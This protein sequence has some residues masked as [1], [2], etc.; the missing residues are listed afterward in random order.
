MPEIFISYRREDSSGHAGRIFDCMCE[1]FSEASVFMD[2]TDIEPGVDF[3]AALDTALAS[4]RVVLVV[5]GT[6]WLTVM[7]SSGHRRLDDPEDHLRLEIARALA[8]DV[9]VIPIL[10]RGATMPREHDLPDDL[11]PLAHRQAHEL[12]DSRWAFD[13]DQLIRLV[14]RDLGATVGGGEPRRAGA[15]ASLVDAVARPLKRSPIRFLAP[16][17][18]LLV[19]LAL[20]AAFKWFAIG[21]EREASRPPLPGGPGGTVTGVRDPAAPSGPRTIDV[22]ENPPA[23]LPAS[24]EVRAGFATFRLLGGLVSASG[25][26]P[27]TVRF[28]VRITNVGAMPLVVAPDSFRLIVDGRATP[29]AEAPVLVVA[30][31][32]ASEGWVVF[33]VPPNAGSVAL[34][35]GDVGKQTAKIPIDLRRADTGVGDKPPPIWRYPVDLAATFVKRVGPLVFH[36]AGARLEHFGDG[37]PPLQPEQLLLSFKVRIENVGTQLTVVSGDLFRLLIDGVPLAPTR[38]PVAALQSQASLDGDVEF[39]MPG[40]ATNASLQIGTVNAETAKVPIDLS[41]AH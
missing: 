12:S 15:P 4:C 39:V 2:V 28:F 14:E 13:T 23:R 29:P 24:G 16:A 5:I 10:V 36:L 18:V 34:Q 19:L 32:S 33:P 3:T 25:G 21:P 17:A 8:K 22:R 6:Q 41:A 37:V 7:D 35:V 20:V 11:Q 27:H 40:T 30:I 9:H 1:R 26:E 31:Q 38:A